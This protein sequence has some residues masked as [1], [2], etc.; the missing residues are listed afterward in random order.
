M[1]PPTE[2]NTK[3]EDNQESKDKT[4]IKSKK[5]WKDLN[6]DDNIIEALR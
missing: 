4:Y 3:Q 6:V 2:Q 1:D 5:K